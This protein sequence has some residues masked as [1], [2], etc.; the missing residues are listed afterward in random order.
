VTALL[1]LPVAMPLLAAALIAATGRLL[2]GRVLHILAIAVSAATTAVTAVLFARSWSGTVIGWFG[3][4][5]PRHGIAVGIAFAADPMG[6]GLASFAAL[7]VTVALVFSW[8]YFDA[9]AALFHT[10]LLVFLGA[11][12]GF[13]LT[14]D[15]FNLFVFFE[16]M[17]VAAYAL[18]SYASS[19][20][21]PLQGGFA[22]AV[23]NS[24]GAFLV[25]TG[26]ALLYGRTGA[27]NLAQIGSALAGRP[28][29]GLVV[30]S[31]T[32]IA[33][34][35]L[36]KAAAVPFHFWLADAY[37]AA[38]TPVC[39][40]FS[41]VMSDLGLYALARVYWSV[42]SGPFASSGHLRAVLVG[43]ACLTML[44]GAVM[45][46][47][48]RHLKRLLAFVTISRG[49]VLLAG[50]ALLTPAGLAGAAIGVVGDG[51]VK[52]ALFLGVGVVI[53][54]LRSGDELVLHGRGHRLPISVAAFTIGALLLAGLPPFAGFLGT[55]MIE[56]SAS[57]VGLGWIAIVIGVSSALAAAAILRAAGRIFL[58]LGPPSDPLLSKEGDAPEADEPRSKQSLR[59][60]A[61][62]SAVA[63]LL[64]LAVAFGFVPRLGTHALQAAGLAEN[65]G[66]YAATILQ[67]SP[68]H[69]P[70][71]VRVP[72]STAHYVEGL[73]TAAGAV[74]FAL[75]AVYHG[76][77][78]AGVRR[79]GS[80][81]LPALRGLKA[82]H[83]GRIGDYVAWLTVGTAT[84][85]LLLAGIA[86]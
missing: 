40:V 15:L 65:R 34:G 2:P 30:V 66:A 3:G 28:V 18:A 62:I 55:T 50:I 31:F 51:L 41:A 58:G 12:V 33:S 54:L 26:I 74:L 29:D 45:A 81:M 63:S 1:W 84:L 36:V 37:A 78:R 9:T 69:L 14:A 49:G 13:A 10:L 24:I 48:Q 23:T 4:W 44:I 22:F 20:V 16:L 35:F 67:G 27:L 25:L 42:Y 59:P 77:L 86:R 38:P 6:A 75:G 5:H 39:A 60:R 8:H 80:P 43:V 19:E 56:D 82:L 79:L 68:S 32:L 53:H 57:T 21:A 61:M 46:L 76:R 73:L 52:A 17:S 70:R 72:T 85:G 47:L 7:I 64:V 71:P 11:M 83:S